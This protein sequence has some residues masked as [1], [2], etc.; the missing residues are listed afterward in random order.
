M[1]RSIA[2]CTEPHSQVLWPVAHSNH[3]ETK[4]WAQGWGLTDAASG[5]KWGLGW[6]G[7]AC[8]GGRGC[9]RT[10]EILRQ[11]DQFV[12]NCL[13]RNVFKCSTECISDVAIRQPSHIMPRTNLSEMGMG[14]AG[15]QHRLSHP[16]AW[17]R[18]LSGS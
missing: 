11:H 10:T 1:R 15:G 14:V 17:P 3:T 18:L 13:H 2:R 7:Q 4:P 6:Q 12:P 9:R 16:L 5:G 8:V